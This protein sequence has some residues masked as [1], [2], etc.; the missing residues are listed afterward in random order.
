MDFLKKVG[1]GV[2]TASLGLSLM[3]GGTY[4]YFSDSETTNNTFGMGTLDLSVDPTAIVEVDNLKP[5]DTVMREFVL[6]NEGTLNI[7]A[8]HL[9][10]DYVVNDV[11]GDNGEEDL[12]KHIRVN[13]MWN[14]DKESEPIFETTLSELKSMD[15]DVVKKDIFDPL[16]EQHGGLDVGMENTLWVEFEFVDNGEDQNMFQGD[17][18][19]LEWNFNA[20]QTD[21]EEK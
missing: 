19:Q 18:L 6:A 12:G 11:E 13:F 17:D 20:K 7:E 14:W 16:W 15:P 4:A 3:G 2:V 5:G 21:S 9:L 8:I 1:A 10:T